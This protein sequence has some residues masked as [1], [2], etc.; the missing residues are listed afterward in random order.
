MVPGCKKRVRSVRLG[1][2]PI[3]PINVVVSKG[4]Q[5]SSRRMISRYRSISEGRS[6]VVTFLEAFN[7]FADDRG[8]IDAESLA[9]ALGGEMNADQ[10]GSGLQ[11]GR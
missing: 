3:L 1:C 2:T 11:C 9:K 5:F 6:L 10:C 4:F 7:V 8:Q